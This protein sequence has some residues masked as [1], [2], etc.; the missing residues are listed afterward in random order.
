VATRYVVVRVHTM[1]KYFLSTHH[2]TPSLLHGAPTMHK[3]VLVHSGPIQKNT[4]DGPNKLRCVFH[5][6]HTT[7]RVRGTTECSTDRA[8]AL[9]EKFGK[10]DQSEWGRMTNFFW[11]L[12]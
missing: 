1:K 12:C 8:C 10:S 4:K 11:P 2:H 3:W 5:F 9:N 7:E 6:T